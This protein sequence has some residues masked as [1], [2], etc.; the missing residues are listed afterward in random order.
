VS[1]KLA[2]KCEPYDLFAF[3]RSYPDTFFDVK[4]WQNHLTEVQLT[5][6]AQSRLTDCTVTTALWTE[7]GPANVA[8]RC[9][10]L[11]VKPNDDNTVLAGFAG[12]GIFKS[13]DG[14]VNWRPV[15]DDHLQL[16]IGHI[17]FDPTQPNIVYAGTGDPNLPAIVFNGNGLYKSTDAGETWKYMGLAEAGIISKISINPDNPKK[18]LVATMGNPYVRDNNRGIYKSNDAG[19]NW[20]QVLFLSNQ[21]GASDL[22]QSAANPDIVYASFWDRIRNNKESVIYG[23]GARVFKST[24]GGDTW[25]K[26]GD[27][28]PNITMGRTGL[29]LSKTDP[30]KLYVLYIDS[31]ST[32][33]GLYKTTNGGE[34]WTSLNINSLENSCGDFGWYFGK[35]RLNPLDDEDLYFLAVTMHRKLPGSSTWIPAGGG[36]ADSHD[37][38][39]TPSGRRYWAN[40]GG[41]YRNDPGQQ[42]WAKCK[43]LPTTQFYHTDFNPH[44]PNV[45][46]GG[47]Q[48]NGIQKGQG[49]AAINNWSSVFSADGFNCA[50]HPTDSLTFWI[51]IQNGTIHKT[52]DGGDSWQFGNVAL[53]SPDRVNWDAPFFISKFNAEKLY[54]ATYKV[55][56]SAGSG[57]GSIS[58]DL[59]DGIIFNPRFHTVSALQES[60]I[61]ADKLMA[62]TS[63]GNVWRREPTSNWVN[64][65][66]TLPNRYVTS[67][68]LSPTLPQ[69]LFVT[70]S[71]FRDD[72]YIPHVHRSDDNGNSWVDISGDLPQIPVNDLFVLPN[73][74][75][76]ILF[77][78][79]DGGVYYTKSSGIHWDR[80]GRNMPFV[81]VFD[82]EENP[83]KK[84]LIAATYARGL[85]TMPFDSILQQQSSIVVSVSGTVRT[86]TG[87]GINNVQVGSE[88]SGMDGGFMLENI[89]GCSTLSITPYRNDNHLNGITT[90]DLVLISKHILGVEALVSPYKMIAADANNSGGITTSDVVAFRKLIL[91][92]DDTLKEQ[93]SW[94]FLPKTQSFTNHENPFEDLLVGSINS[95]LEASPLAE[96]DF[97]GIKMGDVND[98]VSPNVNGDPNDRTEGSIP[99]EIKD[100]EFKAGERFES[101]VRLDCRQVEAIQ[102]GLQIDATQLELESIEPLAAFVSE[103]NF[104]K[105]PLKP[106]LLT[107]AILTNGP[108][109][110]ASEPLF[111]LKWRAKTPGRLSTAIQLLDSPTPGLVYQTGGTALQPVLW[112]AAEQKISITLQ[113]NPANENGCWV[114]LFSKETL[115]PQLFELFDQTGKKIFDNVLPN[116]NKLHLAGSLFPSNGVYYWQ[117]KQLGQSGKL[118]F[119]K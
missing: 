109:A 20:Q 23:P 49:G 88:I 86:E 114:E 13:T 92:I 71:G 93:N 5:E 16:A 97:I 89:P 33:G 32:P 66:S 45:Y 67:V 70:H 101:E 24:D 17:V 90:Y 35:I 29:A 19:E 63:D 12:G 111:R 75:D 31:L 53:G 112:N 102:F 22:A 48:D 113:P 107:V 7:Q 58:P 61:L 51:E 25:F 106:N 108:S 116:G 110:L 87:L 36:H 46:W 15:F 100:V 72:E 91:G 43:N 2:Q 34:S 38:V 119:F 26:L 54:S 41:V 4:A 27:G 37:L 117:I 80:L 68:Q 84:E 47:T 57:W 10:T 14:G 60:P 11:A 118:L 98:S 52:M 8:G 76:S 30:N 81:P 96:V 85:W 6:N 28:L 62:G 79:T 115:E 94:R 55:Y 64:I 69:R 99:L 56:V 74:A 73:H 3:Q 40:D 1:D 39:F 78:A 42:T 18:L 95:Q 103:D 83:V 104:G 21:A 82:L 77:V 50:F 105:P 44:Q 9:N 65:T 59:T